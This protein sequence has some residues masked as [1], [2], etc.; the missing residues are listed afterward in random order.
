MSEPQDEIIGKYRI[1]ETLGKGSMGLVY[2]AEDPEIGRVVALKTLKSVYLGDDALGNEAL[3][4]FKQESRSAGQLQ[5][6]NIVRI[7]EAGKSDD[8]S[9]FIA[10]ELI[11]GKSLELLVH[12]R[13]KLH[14]AETLHYMAQIADAIDY[15]HGKSIIHRDIKPSN[16]LIG[17]RHQPYLLDF[18]V[19]KL[20][21]TSL[22]PVGTIV[23]TPSYMSPEQIR[24]EPLDGR[25][26]V[27]SLAVLVY[28]A[29]SGKRPFPGQE[30]TTV[31]GNIIQKEPLPFTAVELKLP[32]AFEAVLL[33][34]LAKKKEERFANSLELIVALGETISLVLDGRGL[35]GG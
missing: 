35:V 16:V 32:A 34:G 27:F 33:K 17:S 11:E 19:A 12:E 30:F 4:R 14:V 9:P 15:A 22:T 18:G 29:L 25:T 20:S 6:P 13:G 5:H 3:L 21:D 7:F 24:G 2:K 10:M 31:V 8:G 26:D 1:I 28:E 23:G